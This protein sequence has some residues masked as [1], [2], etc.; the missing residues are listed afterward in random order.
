MAKIDWEAIQQRVREQNALKN[1]PKPVAEQSKTEQPQARVKQQLR[2]EP[3]TVGRET[4]K[5]AE[6]RAR[7][8]KVAEREGVKTEAVALLGMVGAVEGF[9]NMSAIYNV[10]DQRM[11]D[12]E[13]MKA[14]TAINEG[15]ARARA[16]HRLEDIHK[17][18]DAE[19]REKGT[20]YARPS[21]W[22]RLFAVLKKATNPG[23]HVPHVFA[24]ESSADRSA[25]RAWANQFEL[26][27]D[28]LVHAAKAIREDWEHITGRWFNA[29]DVIAKIQSFT[30][31]QLNEVVR[32]GFEDDD[33][34]VQ[35]EEGEYIPMKE[36]PNRY[37]RTVMRRRSMDITVE[38]D[39]EVGPR[40]A[41][42]TEADLERRN[43]K[44]R[45][46]MER[47]DAEH[48]QAVVGDRNSH[49]YENGIIAG[50]FA[51]ID[52][53]GGGLTGYGYHGI[54]EPELKKIL[55]EGY[56]IEEKSVP[57]I[58]RHDGETVTNV[59]QYLFHK[60]GP[61]LMDEERIIPRKASLESAATQYIARVLAYGEKEDWR[62]GHVETPHYW[63][64]VHWIYKR[65]VE[66]RLPFLVKLS[67]IDATP[68]LKFSSEDAEK[69]W[70]FDR[71][72]SSGVT[73]S[74]QLD[75]KKKHFELMLEDVF[76]SD[77]DRAALHEVE[78]QF[79]KTILL[80]GC[81]FEVE[82]KWNAERTAIQRATIAIEDGSSSEA[83]AWHLKNAKQSE[84]PVIGNPENPIPLVFSFVRAIGS[85]RERPREFPA[86]RLR[87][88]LEIIE[89]QEQ[90]LRR[91]WNDFQT[92]NE[93]GKMAIDVTI[94]PEESFP[95]PEIIALVM[96]GKPQKAVYATDRNGVDHDAYA[97]IGYVEG[98]AYRIFYVSTK[99]SA[100]AYLAR[101]K[102]KHAERV[103]AAKAREERG[104]DSANPE[105]QKVR[106]LQTK[107]DGYMKEFE[108]DN[109]V[110][111]V[112]GTEPLSTGD[113]NRIQAAL[114]EGKYT[115]AE[116]YLGN[117]ISDREQK[118]E[119]IDS[120]RKVSE[121][122]TKLIALG[123]DWNRFDINKKD[124]EWREE[125]E[126]SRGYDYDYRFP[127]DKKDHDGFYPTETKIH[128]YEVYLPSMGRKTGH[129]LD[130]WRLKEALPSLYRQLELKLE[131]WNM[132][133]EKLRHDREEARKAG[134]SID[135]MPE[136]IER[137]VYQLGDEEDTENVKD[138]GGHQPQNDEDD[139]GEI[140]HLGGGTFRFTKKPKQK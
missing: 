1:P 133:K 78:K 50:V 8:L 21:D 101:S 90:F 98:N 23:H 47:Y 116:L 43:Q 115:N 100:D 92:Y 4:L 131:L 30:A 109:L 64:D 117:A 46:I 34:Y 31:E 49:A 137:G 19:M 132:K 96:E 44:H 73:T 91:K 13:R 119:L 69:D 51:A 40:E 7:M 107:M 136:V 88:L 71:I 86:D 66:D 112:L 53:R 56:L 102:A 128:N 24:V 80:G 15:Q 17:K 103:A 130:M 18:F 93:V 79:P 126:Y 140:E 52:Q 20:G 54:I 94:T 113:Q 33:T 57:Y 138:L 41:V 48:F 35:A 77:A 55:P 9:T 32:A 125:V 27:G 129:R 114:D 72:L 124:R 2:P 75:E 82:Y 118:Q 104:D 139:E 134:K 3:P 42:K 65:L 25:F 36:L 11:I 123:F 16:H 108:N 127:S 95:S 81:F 105:F 106:E 58:R 84:I 83:N 97:T 70:M 59:H 37:D 76:T 67:G 29:S 5:P 120:M 89:P 99:Q 10:P 87:E 28:G 26:N 122:V 14:R 6:R 61:Q 62:M 110:A 111:F 45:Q 63:S 38:L 39:R 121:L 12:A 135:D 60:D 74:K 68:L 22:T 85:F